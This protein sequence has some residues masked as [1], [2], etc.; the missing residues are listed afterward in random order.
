MVAYTKPP[1]GIA[2]LGPVPCAHIAEALV[3]CKQQGRVAFGTAIKGLFID[4]DGV[5]PL[6]LSG[7]R[8]L[9]HAS[10]TD[11]GKPETRKFFK[12]PKA[13]YQGTFIRW[14]DANNA[15]KHPDPA[16]RP[17][18]TGDDTPFMGFYEVADLAPCDVPFSLLK[19]RNSGARVNAPLRRPW[20][21]IDT[22][23]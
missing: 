17:V 13:T 5:T 21:V 19:H 20:L 18:S 8:V 6:I 7:L 12:G 16:V 22:A 23:T 10:Q 2:L 1:N 15:G 3:T 4:K 14:R 9:I 11:G